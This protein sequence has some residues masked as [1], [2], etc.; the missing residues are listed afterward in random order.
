MRATTSAAKGC[1][2]RRSTTRARRPTSPAMTAGGPVT[3]S[4]RSSAARP[5]TISVA[6]SRPRA[7]APTARRG[8]ARTTAGACFPAASL[9]WTISDEPMMSTMFG[10]NS[11]K[12]RGSFG[13]T[14]NQAIP[15]DFASI[16][17]YGRASYTQEPGLGLVNLANPDLRWETTREYDGGFDLGVM[18]SRI[19]LI[20]DVYSKETSDL[21]V[22]RPISAARYGLRR[23]AERRQHQNSGVERA[24]HDATSPPATR[25]HL[26]DA[27]STSRR[28]G[29]RSFAL[30]RR[31]LL[32]GVHLNR[33]R[34]AIRLASST[35]LRSSLPAMRCTRT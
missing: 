17:R 24:G 2:A 19:T 11:L 30:R 9:A 18:N 15:S 1:R 35:P 8:S 25:V 6:T 26:D 20:A 12:L 28:T 5:T 14:G 27:T 29:T 16:Q 22:N 10:N 21:L 13:E 33:C 7:S 32:A 23:S 31:A 4:P 3:T 34:S